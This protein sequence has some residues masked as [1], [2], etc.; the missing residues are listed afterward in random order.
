M[1][2]ISDI[3]SPKVAS[4]LNAGGIVVLRTDTIY[5]MLARADDQNAVKRVYALK[6]RDEAKSPIVLI[7]DLSQLFDPVSKEISKITEN[8]WPGRVSVIIPS[9]HAPA[10]IR[11]DN[12]S[13]AYRLPASQALQGLIAGTGP[14]IAPSA[15]PQNSTPAMNIDQAIEYFGELIDLYVDGGEV[16]DNTPSRLL[17]IHKDGRL[18]QLR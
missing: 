13:V 7:R 14:L 6:G 4:I 3:S 16:D 17:K 2:V 15:N 8:V 5:G 1:N 9:T 11:R 10:W 18:E 12:Q